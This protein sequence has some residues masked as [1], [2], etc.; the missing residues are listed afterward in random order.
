MQL[1]LSAAV[2][3]AYAS[4]FAGGPPARLGV[5]LS[6]GGDSTALLL[7]TRAA[8][9]ETQVFAATVDHRLREGSAAEAA[10]AGTLCERLGVAH[11]ILEWEGWAGEGNLQDAARAARR[12]LLSDWAARHGIAHVALGH[13]RNDQAE[14]V[15]LRL[16]R[17]SGV[18]GLAAM[19]GAS[20]AEGVTW[21]RPLLG[22]SREDLREYLRAQ[23]ERW[24]EDPSNDDPRFDRI[25]ARQ[26]MAAL[27]DLGLTPERLSRT[28]RQMA[29]ARDALDHAAAALLSDHAELH[30]GDVLLPPLDTLDAPEETRLRAFAHVLSW[31]ASAPYRPRFDALSATLHGLPPGKSATLHGCLVSHAQGRWRIAREY[32]AVASEAARPGAPW[33]GRWRLSGPRPP[34]GSHVAAL[35]EIGL[36]DCPDWRASG[37]PRSSVLA[38]PA[39]WQ[40]ERLLAA[41]LAGRPNGYAARLCHGREHLVSSL[42]PD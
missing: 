1:S 20:R 25:R 41:P 31:V 36:A 19:A 15:L 28:A 26:M 12:A 6:G 2:S 33:D 24:A 40:G 27:S 39:L 37:L 23:G 34:A 11:E 5:A 18:D 10:E 7:L 35:G 14:T 21:L 3:D 32:A 13:T 22:L 8:L 16:A 9:P 42:A 38:S 30:Q 29:L 4:L 17:G